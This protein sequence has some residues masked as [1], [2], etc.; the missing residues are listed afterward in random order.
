MPPAQEGQ[1]QGL[2]L[3]I[4][5]RWRQYNCTFCGL[6]FSSRL[7]LPTHLLD[8]RVRS[9]VRATS[10]GLDFVWYDPMR[11]PNDVAH[12]FNARDAVLQRE[13][14]KAGRTHQIVQ[15][16]ATTSAAKASAGVPARLL[17]H[18][19]PNSVKR[20]LSARATTAIASLRHIPR[21]YVHCSDGRLNRINAKSSVI[22]YAD[23]GIS[24][25][26]EMI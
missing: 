11:L 24:R 26:D 17:P 5:A 19:A 4:P 15:V 23:L 14:R 22:R 1:A 21:S 6:S 2:V 8:T 12:A 18:L 3:G 16:P 10:Y 7:S 13:A 9:K 25:D 20:R